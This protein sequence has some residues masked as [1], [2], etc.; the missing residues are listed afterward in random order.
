MCN[1]AVHKR[2]TLL[3]NV[4]DW[5]VRSQQVNLWYDDYY[6]NDDYDKIIKWYE[7]YQRGK[8]QKFKI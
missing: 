8:A 5:F 7:I 1:E 6:D 3:E 4:T 2:S